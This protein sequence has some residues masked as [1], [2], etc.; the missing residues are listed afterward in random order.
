LKSFKKLKDL[1]AFISLTYKDE[2][3]TLALLPQI[4]VKKNVLGKVSNEELMEKVE[5]FLNE[6]LA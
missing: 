6:I 5:K 1:R 3:K 4:P 2:A